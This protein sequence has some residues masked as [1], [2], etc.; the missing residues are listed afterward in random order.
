MVKRWTLHHCDILY[1]IEHWITAIYCITLLKY[2]Y[3]CFFQKYISLRCL[4]KL[5][6]DT[7]FK[8]IPALKPWKSIHR[9]TSTNLHKC[10][11]AFC[12]CR[13][14]NFINLMPRLSLNINNNNTAL[15]NKLFVTNMINYC[16]WVSSF[17]KKN[18]L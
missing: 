16:N 11:K 5:N 12:S 9:N 8:F 15:L 14:P 10:F 6:L 2:R 1:N 7:I 13:M 18:A 17:Y 4:R 3:E